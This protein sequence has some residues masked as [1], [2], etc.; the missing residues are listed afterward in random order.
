MKSNGSELIN[1]AQELAIQIKNDLSTHKGERFTKSQIRVAYKIP[2]VKA[3]T[4][5]EILSTMGLEVSRIEVAV[6]AD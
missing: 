3:V 6:P 1:D 4:V 5:W 2:W